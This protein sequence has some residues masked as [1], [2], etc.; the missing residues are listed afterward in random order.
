MKKTTAKILAFSTLALLSNSAI[1]QPWVTPATAPDAQ[2]SSGFTNIRFNPQTYASGTYNSIFGNSGGT[3]L[4]LN[5]NTGW[6]NGASI[7]MNGDSRGNSSDGS[8]SFFTNSGTSN[9]GGGFIFSRYNQSTTN[10]E[11][12]LQITESGEIF[13]HNNIGMGTFSGLTERLNIDGN[14]RFT[15]TGNS[16]YRSIFGSSNTS[17]LY[18]NAATGWG[19]GASIIMNGDNHGNSSDGSLSFFT[20]SG[21]SNSGGG[22]T[23]SRYNQGTSTWEPRMIITESGN[24]LIGD[25]TDNWNYKLFVEKGILTEKVKVALKS[26]SEW[27]DYVFANDYKLKSLNEVEK[28]IAANKHLPDVPSAEEVVKEGIDMATMDAKLLQKIE[29]LTLY[30]IQLKKEIDELKKQGK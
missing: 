10:W 25:V 13:M 6:S 24:V 3:G 29:E 14:I 27:S 22:F 12:R 4:Y 20:N 15:P 9:S 1:A 2:A 11:E 16:G 8:L 21:A 30:T 5:A 23:F 17:G 7:I 28:Y 26:T 19:N 18:L